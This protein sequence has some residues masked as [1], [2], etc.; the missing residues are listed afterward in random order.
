MSDFHTREQWRL[1]C[2]NDGNKEK[3][4]Y[5]VVFLSGV[6]RESYINDKIRVEGQACGDIL[7]ADYIDSYRNISI[8]DLAC[9]TGFHEA[10]E[11]ACH[12]VI[13]TT[14]QYLSFKHDSTESKRRATEQIDTLCTSALCASTL[15]SR[16]LQKRSA[17][18]SIRRSSHFVQC[19]DR[20]VHL[21]LI[22]NYSIHSLPW[23]RLR[24]STSLPT[25]VT[26]QKQKFLGMKTLNV[27]SLV[28]LVNSLYAYQADTLYKDEPTHNYRNYKL[29]RIYPDN[30]DTLKYLNT[31]Y[32]G[33]SPYELD[34]WQPPTRIGGI[35]DVTVA[36]SDAPIFVRDLESKKLNF[37]VAVNDLAQAIENERSP[38]A[39]HH[40]EAGGYSYDKYNTLEDIH[41]EMMRLRKEKPGMISLID[42]GE[43]HE[44]RTLLVIKI[45]GQ[46]PVMGKKA[47]MWIDAGIHAREWIAP[48]TAMYIVHEL[49]HGYDSNPAIQRILDHVDFYILP[50]MNPD[51]YEYSRL[52]NRMWRKNRRPATC[53]RQHFHTVCCGG[54]D[55][56]RNFDW[57]WASTGSSTDPCHETYHGPDAFSEPETQAVRDY[58]QANRPEAFIT[59][60]SYSQMW[61]IPYGH[62]K[63]S[64][65]QDYHTALRPLADRATKALYD[66]Y[67]TKYQVGTGA[68]L[69]YEASGGSHDWAKGTLKVSYAYL[70]ELRP[71]NTALGY[72]FLLPEREIAAT[73]LETFE[74]IKVVAD[75]LIFQFVESELRRTVKPTPPPYPKRRGY[76]V[77]ETTPHEQPSYTTTLHETSTVTLTSTSTTTSMT[78]TT[79]TTP[80]ETTT[81]SATA[82][83]TA[84]V[85]AGPEV[86]CVDYGSYCRL[87][88][89]L[90]LCDRPSVM[91]M[92]VKTCHRSCRS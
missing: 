42:I 52:K 26:G 23:S 56:N 46:K 78:P 49:V 72:G 79:T 82:T 27:L 12:P 40:P 61:L 90:N 73:G 2:A 43:T 36:P 7:Q 21:V 74:A 88:G 60:H 17:A 44:N 31:L 24:T 41:G 81:I 4:H 10:T 20:W 91:D 77:I 14:D 59:L 68:D 16:R 9:T 87:W 83:T 51:G 30:D 89:V 11:Q 58:L 28:V 67:G 65:P 54:V 80:A 19:S 8:K 92:C 32:E 37:I 13:I 70:I 5:S 47:S 71:K 38:E 86:K 62:R 22:A 55:L 25:Q 29:I 66:L 50:V 75:E 69:M 15:C 63:R 64:Y 33:S 85:D 76:K 48:A 18:L 1:T 6:A 39:F 84:V 45:S 35:V 3:F 57:F 34:F 53:R